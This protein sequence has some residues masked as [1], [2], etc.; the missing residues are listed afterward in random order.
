MWMPQRSQVT[1]ATIPLHEKSALT[2]RSPFTIAT[3]TLLAW[4]FAHLSTESTWK[5]GVE[6]AMTNDDTITIEAL[7]QRYY[8]LIFGRILSL[9]RDPYLAE[10]LTQDTFLR[11]MRALPTL[12]HRS[13]LL[14][15]LYTIA[16]HLAI[17]SYRRRKHAMLP[18][19][20]VEV[21]DPENALD[22]V[23]DRDLIDHIL[24]LLCQAQREALLAKANGFRVQKQVL[25][26]ARQNFRHLYWQRMHESEG[27]A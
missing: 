26:R 3:I 13:N 19:A 5:S 17:D 10:D 24:S 2:I 6:E 15:W 20:E 21:I 4:S 8:P 11:A 1:T 16:T 22:E 27:A 9:V 7:Y 25:F 18:L 12:S 14:S 23:I